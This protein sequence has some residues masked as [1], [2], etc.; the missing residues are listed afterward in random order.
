MSPDGKNAK[1]D[2]STPCEHLEDAVLVQVTAIGGQ[3][4]TLVGPYRGE[5]GLHVRKFGNA[6]R[7][8]RRRPAAGAKGTREEIW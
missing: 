7:F 6:P 4:D 3:Q 2:A 5:A 1:P 8:T